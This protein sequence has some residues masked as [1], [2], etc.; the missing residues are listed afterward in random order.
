MSRK[1]TPIPHGIGAL[2]VTSLVYE[3]GSTGFERE[4]IVLDTRSRLPLHGKLDFR[5][6]LT[7]KGGD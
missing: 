4:T 7:E 3:C 1:H 5:R 2:E 6:L